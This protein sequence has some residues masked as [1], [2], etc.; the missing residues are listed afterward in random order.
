MRE[1]LETLSTLKSLFREDTCFHTRYHF[2][3]FENFQAPTCIQEHLETSNAVEYP[4]FRSVF[5]YPS[6]ILDFAMTLSEV[7]PEEIPTEQSTFFMLV[8]PI[9][10]ISHCAFA[11]H[12]VPMSW[13]LW[14]TKASATAASSTT[15]CRRSLLLLLDRLEASMCSREDGGA[16]TPSRTHGCGDVDM[17]K[18][19]NYKQLPLVAGFVI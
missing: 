11:Q 14:C 10:N 8:H 15:C 17:D 6:R 19:F 18:S 2:L 4:V 13:L 3:Q 7:P 9:Y 1:A 16:A 12:L 5:L